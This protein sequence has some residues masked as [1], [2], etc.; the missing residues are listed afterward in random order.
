MKWTGQI[1]CYV[2]LSITLIYCVVISKSVIK[3]IQGNTETTDYSVKK[4]IFYCG[5][6]SNNSVS[7]QVSLTFV[8]HMSRGH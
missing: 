5:Y 8:K 3:T 6:F 7:L 4:E 2:V 1:K